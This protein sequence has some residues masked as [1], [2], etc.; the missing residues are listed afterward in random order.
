MAKGDWFNSDYY[1]TQKVAQMNAIAWQ[2]K[3]DWDVASYQQELA[4]WQGTGVTALQNFEACNTLGYTSS[5]TAADI[6]VAPNKYFDVPV[7]LQNV[8]DYANS[9]NWT[10]PAYT[11]VGA[12]EWT[13]QNVLS[14]MVSKGISAWAHYTTEGMANGINPSNI[15]DTNAYLEARAQAMGDGATAATALAAIKAA[16]QNAIQDFLDN[17][18]DLG[19]T[20]APIDTTP[21]TP[22][23]PAGWTQWSTGATP[24]P[25]ETDPYEQNV[26]VVDITADQLTYPG[27]GETYSGNTKFEGIWSSN[28]ADRTMNV[29]DVIT[30]PAGQYNTLSIDMGQDWKGFT[31]PTVDGKVVDNVTNVGRIELNHTSLNTER[32][33]TFDAT[34]IAGA[35]RVDINNTG[36]GPISLKNL[37]AS[38]NQINIDTLTAQNVNSTNILPTTIAYAQGELNGKED[39]LTLG[40]TNV[41]AEGKFAPIIGQDIETLTV[42]SMGTDGNYVNLN[43]FTGVK[44]LNITG[45]GNISISD[46]ADGIKTYDA[47]EATG[48]VNMAVSNITSATVVKGGSGFDAVTL[49]DN[50]T[51]HP[52]SWTGIESLVS[53]KGG[54]INA[55]NIE[56]LQ[57]LWLSGQNQSFTLKNL[58]AT[59]FNIHQ[60]VNGAN[61]TVKGDITNL[62]WSTA[63]AKDMGSFGGT[64]TSDVK[65]NVTLNVLNKDGS[66]LDATFKN[67][68]GTITLNVAEGENNDTAD[69]WGSIT[70]ADAEKFIVN[71]DGYLGDMAVFRVVDGTP[72]AGR[73]VTINSAGPMYKITE[74]NKGATVSKTDGSDGLTLDA[75]GATELTI[76]ATGSF[77]LDGASS[78]KGAQD[79]NITLDA[80]WDQTT[81]VDG[82]D[83][84]APS[85]FVIGTDL[86][87]AQTVDI[88]AGGDEV[89]LQN[90]GT[91]IKGN[92]EIDLNVSDAQTFT[93]GK[94]ET[95]L[96]WNINANIASTGDVTFGTAIQTSTNTSGNTQGDVNIT[97]STET[98]DGVGGKVESSGPATISA[99]DI[100][101]NFSDVAGDAFSTNGVTL[102]ASE[103]IT[104]EGAAGA[105]KVTIDA[106]GAGTT[107]N[108]ISL[109]NG[110]DN[111]TITATANTGKM[112]QINLDL[113]EDSHVKDEITINAQSKGTLAVEVSGWD[114][115]DKLTFTSA[116]A[117][118]LTQSQAST[119]LSSFG[120]SAGTLYKAAGTVSGTGITATDGLTDGTD[121]YLFNAAENATTLVVIEGAI[122]L[123]MTLGD[124]LSA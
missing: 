12:G 120:L 24:A 116:D 123:G 26:S 54:S 80:L 64:L 81:K 121:L 58:T 114:A 75:D 100:S 20:D 113:S 40:L 109:G 122:D 38:V 88:N 110:A 74:E 62:T 57:E 87:A 36:A 48:Q 92:G 68:Q 70:A 32:A 77:M 96:G 44:T 67:A 60:F 78:L 30:G 39:S 59:D 98:V 66:G 35:E 37:S 89:Y 83:V 28:S 86:Q 115:S 33:Y 108:N 118:S 4:S 106:I 71:S 13:A 69:F 55:E 79:I 42:K 46:V 31:K 93:V 3:T 65:E 76:N 11:Q 97:V 51:I 63:G 21:T 34:G 72:A 82:K 61:T 5:I 73:S 27:E 99:G 94:I 84:S 56:G 8:A 16:G 52:A 18:A 6:N 9:A 41:G 101:L 112:T 119:L 104:Y 103:T 14:Y 49:T 7:Y 105:D 50:V 1:A 43:E 15:F 23:V 91:L 85:K 117:Q 2:G 47:S 29:N 124:A 22:D 90:L 107:A 19:I 25:S 102:K 45:S 17:G 111:F 10:D 95:G 53:N